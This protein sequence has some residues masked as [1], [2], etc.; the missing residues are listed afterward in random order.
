[1]LRQR[2]RA[3]DGA[4][5]TTAGEDA[6]GPRARKGYPVWRKWFRARSTDLFPPFY[7]WVGLILLTVFTLAPFVYLFTSSLSEKQELLSGHLVPHRVTLDNYVRLF[8]GAGA[9]D[10][11][12]AIRNSVT[13]AV[14]TTVFSMVIGVFA[15]YAFA[16]IRFPL[17]MTS[18]F[19]VLAMQILPSISILVP[20]YV[21]MRNGVQIDLPFTGVVLYQSP[22]LLDTVWALVIA[23]TTF[24]LPFVIWLL[25]GY[26]QTIPL[27]LEEASYVDGCN[28]LRAMFQVVLPLSLPGIAATAIFTLLGAWDEFM[29]AN[30]FTQTYASK[31][32][33]IAISEFIGK[34]GMDWGLMTAGGFIASLPPVAISLL[35]YRYIVSGMTAGGVKG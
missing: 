25:A 35:L 33:P 8:T 3:L 7:L 17:R 21:M 31:T 16:R 9:G 12:H 24:S 13:V 27:E 4:R 19:A 28:R 14:W 23:Y 26:F 10:F 18:L 1:M 15:A 5:A 30:A 11:I 22:P 2:D 29:F 34:H 32:L 20:M 6:R